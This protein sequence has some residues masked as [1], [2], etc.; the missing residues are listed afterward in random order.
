MRRS[1]SRNSSLALS[2]T[3]SA[4][5]SSHRCMVYT[6]RHVPIPLLTTA[7]RSICDRNLAGTAMRPFASIVCSYSPRNMPFRAFSPTSRSGGPRQIFLNIL[8][9]SGIFYLLPPPAEHTHHFAPLL[10]TSLYQIIARREKGNWHEFFRT[11][12]ENLWITLL[13]P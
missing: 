12:V 3:N 2:A 13:K 4:D 5:F 11:Q 1:K 8:P 10:P 6:E 7:P 9:H